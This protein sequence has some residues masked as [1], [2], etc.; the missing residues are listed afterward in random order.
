VI[1]VGLGGLLVVWLLARDGYGL[2][3]RHA[4]APVLG[5]RTLAYLAAGVIAVILVW[6]EPTVQLGRPLFGLVGCALLALAAETL[7][8]ASRAD[9]PAAG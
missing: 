8:R 6:W 4:L 5:A 7:H 3:A 2:R 9:T 1:I